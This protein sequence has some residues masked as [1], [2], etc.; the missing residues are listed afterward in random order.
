MMRLGSW[1]ATGT[2]LAVLFG[3]TFYVVWESF[4]SYGWNQ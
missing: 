2:V 3:A 4:T 1:L